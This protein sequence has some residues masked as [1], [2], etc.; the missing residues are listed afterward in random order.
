[1][2]KGFGDL[3]KKN[4]EDTIETR[5]GCGCDQDVREEE[6]EK[7]VEKLWSELERRAKM[8]KLSL[9]TGIMCGGPAGNSKGSVTLST[10]SQQVAKGGD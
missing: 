8:L 9:P 10:S 3:Q 5:W 1:L 2:R 4:D 6:E 7:G